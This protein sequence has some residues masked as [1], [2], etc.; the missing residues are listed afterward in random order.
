MALAIFDL[1]NTLLGGDS[2][3]LW[4]RY[5][6][7]NGIVDADAYRRANEHYYQ[8]YLEG[9]LDIYEFLEF[10]FKPLA[11]HSLGQLY[12]WRENYL[13]QKIKPIILPAAK[14]LIAQHRAKGDTLL[15]ITA[16]NSFITSPI[17][18]MLAIEHLIA[19]EPELIDGRY[20]GHVAG[21]PS[22]HQGKVDRLKQWLVEQNQDLQ[23]S[24]FYSDS[25][26][27]LPLLELVDTAVAVDPDP[28]LQAV[29]QQRGWKILSLRE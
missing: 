14:A 27:D 13:Q 16:T 8:Q 7:E 1:D 9:S 25:H 4:G 10:V 15:I 20:T 6:C 21:I 22:F 5:L 12:E 11:S 19:T 17:A 28:K 26:N 24:I 18:E 3:F 29:A 2:D 23:G